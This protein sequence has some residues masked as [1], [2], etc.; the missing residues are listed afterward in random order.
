MIKMQQK[1]LIMKGIIGVMFFVFLPLFVSAQWFMMQEWPENKTRITLKFLRP[2]LDEKYYDYYQKHLS[3]FS[4]IYDLSINL[5]VYKSKGRL[6]FEASFPIAVNSLENETMRGNLYLGFQ[7]KHSR[8]KNNSIISFGAYLPT[9]TD[10]RWPTFFI[11]LSADNIAFPKYQGKMWAFTANYLS[12]AKLGKFELGY[13]MGPGMAIGDEGYIE[14]ILYLHYGFYGAFR[15]G[16]FT[17]RAELAGFLVVAGA[18]S[19]EDTSIESNSNSIAIGVRYG[20]G[21]I[22][23][24]IFYMRSLNKIVRHD[25]KD[26]L[27]FQ[28]Q[29]LL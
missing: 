13:E 17:F 18:A 12:Y 19:D 1:R 26:V 7:W 20:R 24:A 15:T 14:P 21:V 16:D 5:P 3:L 6:N 29:F 11:A 28:L 22:R 10:N 23:P 9:G 4:G 25:V 2:N 27:G 8:K